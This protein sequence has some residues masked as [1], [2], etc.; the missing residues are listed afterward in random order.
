MRSEK[1]TCTWSAYSIK[2]CLWQASSKHSGAQNGNGL[3][4]VTSASSALTVKNA[5]RHPNHAAAHLAGSTLPT[6]TLTVK[7][8]KIN[9]VISLPKKHRKN[10]T[11]KSNAGQKSWWK[12]RSRLS[13]STFHSHLHTCWSSSCCDT[14]LPLCTEI[15]PPL[16]SQGNKLRC[17]QLPWVQP[18]VWGFFSWFFVFVFK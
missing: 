11:W 12:N 15:Q 16:V 1:E 4:R 6:A 13:P 9:L 7:R 17:V 8:G 5:S 2:T 10:T 3:L 14:G 18:Q